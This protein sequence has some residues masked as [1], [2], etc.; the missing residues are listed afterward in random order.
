[1]C[2]YLR[3]IVAIGADLAVLGGEAEAFLASLAEDPVRRLPGSRGRPPAAAA[4]P[5]GLD[6]LGSTKHLKQIKKL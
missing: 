6:A 3:V 4:P 1:M 2:V 5:S